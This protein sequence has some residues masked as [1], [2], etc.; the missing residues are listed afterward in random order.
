MILTDY[1][2]VEDF[3]NNETIMWFKQ[4]IDG[5]NVSNGNAGYIAVYDVNKSNICA[6]AKQFYDIGYIQKEN[7]PSGYKYIRVSFSNTYINFGIGT[8]DAPKYDYYVAKNWV[9]KS[10][11]DN[12]KEEIENLKK[13]LPAININKECIFYGD[14]ITAQDLFQPLIKEVLGINYI[15]DGNPGYPLSNVFANSND[16]GFSLSS[17]YKLNNLI[18]TINTNSVKYVFIMGGTNDFGYDGTKEPTNEGSFN[19][20]TMGDLSYP[21]NRNT[22][23]GALS[24]II[25]RIQ[26]ECATVEKVF[27]MSP[28][29][30][31]KDNATDIVKNS[32]GLS[33][34]DFR[35]ACEEVANKFSCEFIDVYSCGINFINWSKYIPDKIHPNDSGALL[36]AYVIIA[37]L[38]NMIHI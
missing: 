27:I 3:F 1:I 10:I 28:I 23:K 2:D 26:R 12:L 21:Y 17:T 18:N 4:S 34:L 6:S 38:K 5:L 13:T 22:Y 11:T 30:R 37:Y 15:N 35:N 24:H 8:I 29:Q 36:I 14:S 31:G 33:M 25:D 20:I 7:L 16:H 9:D 19:A 32:L